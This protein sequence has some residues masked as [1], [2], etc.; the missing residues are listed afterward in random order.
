MKGLTFQGQKKISYDST[1][2][3]T[4]LDQNDVIVKVKATAICGSDLH[5]Y[6]GNEKGLIAFAL[7]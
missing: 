2:D 6:R 1:P 3:P 5:V 4:I 7:P